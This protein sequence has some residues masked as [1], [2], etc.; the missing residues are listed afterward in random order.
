MCTCALIITTWLEQLLLCYLVRS[1]LPSLFSHCNMLWC[2]RKMII[3]AWHARKT[4]IWLSPC[5]A[6]P[7]LAPHT[8]EGIGISAPL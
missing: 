3:I 5:S 6:V 8:A 2:T 4:E 1:L 7:G